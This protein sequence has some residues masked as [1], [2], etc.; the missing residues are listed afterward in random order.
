[1][2]V[3]KTE[4]ERGPTTH[5]LT[6]DTKSTS[7]LKGALLVHGMSILTWDG[8]CWFHSVVTAER[9]L[10]KLWPCQFWRKGPLS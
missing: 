1:M 2:K 8:L 10:T 6:Q 5:P 3:D 7:S 9:I 4:Q